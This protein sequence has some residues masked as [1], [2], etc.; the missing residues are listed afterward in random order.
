MSRPPAFDLGSNAA[1]VT[2]NVEDTEDTFFRNQRRVFLLECDR[3]A[4]SVL[5]VSP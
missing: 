4:G 1:P 5:D 2:G 3:F